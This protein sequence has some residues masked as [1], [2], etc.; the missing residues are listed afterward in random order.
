MIRARFT[1]A[2]ATLIA[3]TV[4]SCSGEKKNYMIPDIL[5][6]AYVNPKLTKDLLPGGEKIK[7]FQEESKSS[8][9]YHYCMVYVDGRAELSVEGVWHPAGTTAKQAAEDSLVFNTRSAEGGRFEIGQRRAITVV[10][11]K[12]PR[13]N[14]E[15]FS[16]ELEITNPDGDIGD[17]MHHFLAAFSESYRKTLPCQN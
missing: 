5:C 9:P 4:S 2:L 10:D 14:A 16:F 7:L 15:R 12:N 13:Y 3:L 11:C 8:P 1:A 17:K 6:G